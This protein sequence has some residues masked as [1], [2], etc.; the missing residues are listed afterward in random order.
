MKSN[1]SDQYREEET[2]RRRYATIKRMFAT[3]SKPSS[4]MK[5]GKFRRKVGKSP[6]GVKAQSK[7]RYTVSL[8]DHIAGEFVPYK[9]IDIIARDDNNAIQKADEWVASIPELIEEETWLI[10]KEGARSIRPKKIK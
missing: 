9:Q 3:P 7:K 8:C 2:A 1:P 5:V 4:E 10:I 6:K